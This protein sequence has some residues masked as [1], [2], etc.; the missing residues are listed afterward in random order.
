MALR[1]TFILG[2]VC[3]LAASSG[4]QRA[5]VAAL[6]GG[7]KAVGEARV[8]SAANGDLLVLG[9]PEGT[10]FEPGAKGD[11]KSVAVAFLEK[12]AS[13]FGIRSEKS[14]LGLQSESTGEG[15]SV[16][17][18]QQEYAG[19]PVYGAQ[20]VAQVGADKGIQYVNADLLRHTSGFDEGKVPVTPA[21][22]AEEALLAALAD[23]AAAGA[24]MYVVSEAA[25]ELVVFAPE[26]IG[27]EGLPCLAWSLVLVS[28]ARGAYRQQCFVNAA[29]GEIALSFTLIHTAR[30]RRIF[31]S[32]NTDGDPG[33][34]A[35]SE[36]GAVSSVTDVNLAYEFFG[37]TYDFYQSEHGR[38]SIDGN[39]SILSATVRFCPPDFPEC[40]FPN[41]FWDGSRMYFGE[42]F[43]AADD[44]VA[45]ELT[46]GVTER[47]SDLI[48]FSQSGALNESFSDVWGEIIDQ[49][50][51]A[52][53]DTPGVKWLMGED[54][55]G[56]GALRNMANPPQFGDPDTTCS[57]NWSTDPLDNLG[58]HSNSGINNKL[59][60]LLVDGGS[61]NGRTVTGMGRSKVADL[62]Y[63]V[64]T[65]LITS[66]A[67]FLDLYG[68]LT[69]A[70]I[71]LGWSAME[72]QNLESACTAVQITPATNCKIPPP[73][74]A[75]DECA[76]A[77]TLT[78]NTTVAGNNETATGT[79]TLFCE[80]E[81][82]D[83][84]DVWYRFT[85]PANGT[86]VFSLCG[87]R[88]D[89]TLAVFE[90]TCNNRSLVACNDDFLSCDLAS[91]LSVPLIQGQ[92][93]LVR[94]AAF[95]GAGGAFNLSVTGQSGTAN[96]ECAGAIA[97][98][99]NNPVVGTTAGASTSAGT[100]CNG[101]ADV[102]YKFTPQFTDSYGV[103]VCGSNDA[104]VAVSLGCGG[105]GIGCFTGNCATGHAECLTLNQGTTYFFRVSA[106]GNF[107][108]TLRSDCGSPEG[109][110]EGSNLPAN[111]D[112]SG[113]T[114]I[115]EDHVEE[116]STLLATPS[117]PLG[118]IGNSKDVWYRFTPVVNGDYA[119]SLCNSGFDTK[120][121]VLDGCS[122][123]VVAC[124]DDSQC[125]SRSYVCV[126]LA[127]GNDYRVRVAGY[128]SI[129]GNFELLVTRSD[130]NAPTEGSIEGEGTA[131]GQV[132]GPVN[133]EC[134]GALPVQLDVPAVGST[135]GAT[136]SG[137]T[138]CISGLNK[139]V[140]YR[141]TPPLDGEYTVGLCNSSFDTKL[142]ILSACGGASEACDD[143]GCGFQSVV[144]MPM[145]RSTE[146]RIRVAGF[147]DQTGN[148]QL[149]VTKGNCIAQP[150]GEGKPE[151]SVEGIPV[152]GEGTTGEGEGVTPDGEGAE[153]EGEA[154]VEGAEE[155]EGEGEPVD[156][157]SIHAADFNA[158]GRFGLNE[159]MRLVQL[160]NA[161]RYYCVTGSVTSEDGY[162]VLGG[163]Q[164][165]GRHDGDYLPPFWSFSLAEVLR[166]IQ[167]YNA[168]EYHYCPE[169][170]GSEDHFCLGEK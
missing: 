80:R 22:D 20:V 88:I 16:V 1:S 163:G 17:R 39:G 144:C 145:K 146:Y 46:H 25:P 111:D 139:D 18:L 152:E 170:Q 49:G 11:A 41:A 138:Q 89:T 154:P 97:I 76:N 155:A 102:W 56:F 35:R 112:C 26:V 161:P 64:Q 150:E 77:T 107:T 162:S 132:E 61:F 59:A 95:G 106:S 55:P 5:D 72:K 34:L 53:T 87:S 15:Y 44:V 40:P 142:Q 100:S 115:F 113:A 94:V 159:V 85:A 86:Y 27:T 33:M 57:P 130:C 30:N 28:E 50:N 70:A 118:C 8:I 79:E 167:L 108:L 14:S 29:N 109:E 149:L 78:V 129:S 99:A 31:D 124:N 45:H 169:A 6:L 93:Y 133:D 153:E 128:G 62:Y 32:A 48:Y 38:D 157:A 117:G 98:S 110:P 125:G 121:Q 9:A 84:N 52:G 43:A 143:D 135:A 81:L 126:P 42:G 105:A 66:G 140:W 114:E 158:D 147:L 37:D 92:N 68:A 168:G 12:H 104:E 60:F 47:T 137:Q 19:L 3:L 23:A 91:F 131:D 164:A 65:R 69:Q 165:C 51:G 116:G 166:G 2:A 83:F 36:G 127:G 74:P 96:N 122:S 101:L 58:V 13:S 73:I 24:P 103:L 54:V 10:S 67:S 134:A 71:N 141:F 148:Y 156:P 120:L 160:Y 4:A 123:N 21:L 136:A 151:G 63:E 7:L 75:N 82:F 119:F 90:G